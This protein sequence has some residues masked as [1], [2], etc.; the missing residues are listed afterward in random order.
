M[1]NS[2]PQATYQACIVCGMLGGCSSEDLSAYGSLVLNGESLALT[3][4]EVGILTSGK[5]SVG[6]L[7]YRNINE[8]VLAFDR[9]CTHAGNQLNPLNS[10]GIAVCYRHG[11][12]FNTFGKLHSRPENSN[13]KAYETIVFGNLVSVKIK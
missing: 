6:L 4:S 11:S 13:L 3:K 5:H 2:L 12:K 7:L 8:K 10:S 1:R 9:A